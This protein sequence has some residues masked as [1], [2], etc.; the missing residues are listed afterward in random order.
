MLAGMIG[1]TQGSQ[2]TVSLFQIYVQFF[3]VSNIF[4]G[5]F[6]HVSFIDRTD[7]SSPSPFRIRKA[8]IW[9]R[10]PVPT[11]HILPEAW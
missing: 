4:I 5:K 2:Y 11:V 6:L 10:G 7:P 3:R 8:V 9:H 1:I